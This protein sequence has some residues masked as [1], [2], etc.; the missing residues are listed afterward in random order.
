M[1]ECLRENANFEFD[2]MLDVLPVED[3]AFIDYPPHTLFQNLFKAKESAHKH[4][5]SKPF[6]VK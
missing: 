6:L 2:C 5:F 4:R 3:S 1:A